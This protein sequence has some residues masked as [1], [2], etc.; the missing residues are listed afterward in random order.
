MLLAKMM[1]FDAIL[2]KLATAYILSVPLS[3][4]LFDS[5]FL[6]CDKEMK[7]YCSRADIIHV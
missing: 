7:A 4:I 5:I 6:S 1:L 2:W 3:E